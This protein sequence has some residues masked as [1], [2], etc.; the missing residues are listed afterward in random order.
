LQVREVNFSLNEESDEEES[1]SRETLQAILV[2]FGPK[3]EKTVRQLQYLAAAIIDQGRFAEAEKLL[4][5]TLQL[6]RNV[7]QVDFGIVD[8]VMDNLVIA[9]FR[10]GQT[11]PALQWSIYRAERADECIGENDPRAIGTRKDL[12]ECLR[13]VGRIEESENIFHATIRS[14]MRVRGERHQDTLECMLYY[15]RTLSHEGRDS[16]AESWLRKSLEGSLESFGPEDRITLQSC[17]WLVWCLE[18]QG[19]FDEALQLCERY[20]Q[21][22]NHREGITDQHKHIIKVRAWMDRISE[23]IKMEQR[24]LDTFT[25]EE[26]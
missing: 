9:L 21:E 10:K 8:N 16:E 12:A 13:A 20:L 19:R 5:I 18:T 1:L 26:Q 3:H 15:G 11:E 14:M 25:A 23:R 17:D 2:S 7:P 24:V 6:C 22:L 4:M